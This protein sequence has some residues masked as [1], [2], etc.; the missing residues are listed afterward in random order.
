MIG[1][2]P[3]PY[4]D[5][6]LY[7]ICARFSNRVAYSSSKAVLL[8]VL[9]S[10]TAS[11]VIDLPNH[12]SHIITALPAGTSL[13]V[14]RLINQHSILPFFSSFVPPE[15]VRQLRK[16][17]R[18][19]GGPA[20]HM[21]SGVMA[22]RIPTPE[23]LRYCP[24]CKNEDEKKFGESYWHRVH[25]LPGVDV[26]SIHEIFLENSYVSRKSGRKHLQFTPVEG[27]T[28][29]QPARYLN[30]SDHD[31]QILLQIARDATWLLEHP[32]QGIDLHSLYN[33][34]LGLLIER[35]L[36]TYTGSI[37]VYKLLT[38]F[39]RYYSP[40]LLRLLHYEFTG[41]DQMKTNWL[42]RLVRPPKYAQHPLYH[43]LLMQLL[44]YTAEEFFKLPNE[45]ST[46][47]KGPWPC[48]NPTA[49]HFRKSVI[50]DFRLGKRLRSNRPVGIFSCECGFAYARSG[51]DSSQD[52]RFRIGKMISFG[53]VWEAKLNEL[54]KES[55]L[56]LSEIGRRLGVDPLT[57]RRHAARLNLSSSRG[58]KGSKPLELETKL[59]SGNIS[60][61]KQKRL[62]SCRSKWLSAMRQNPKI[63]LKTL[64]H[65]LA[66]HY[67]WLLQNDR[68][69]LE[70]HK[71]RDQRRK[72]STTSVDWKKRDAEYA[73]RVRDAATQLKEATA[74]PIRVTKTAIGRAIGAITLLQQKLRMMPLTTQVLAD[75]VETR[76]ECALRRVV[77]AATLYWQECALPREWQL[78]MRANVYSLRETSAV[79]CALEDAMEMLKSKLSQNHRIQAAS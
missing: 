4:P 54:W 36:A 42:L 32:R 74:R 22:S 77:W 10:I 13:T 12:L 11:A 45:L 34:Y 76:E 57:V 53:S 18:T 41:R 55:S 52:D 63:T 62:R 26:C 44:S 38:E 3:T 14:D 30:S 67:R 61:V 8:E 47:G 70:G 33:R 75:V 23:R 71:P 39:G 50:V 19:S 1:Y 79:K 37:R 59:K 78:V 58:G 2:F 43:L 7:S 9:G 29:T 69:W 35:G 24:V 20:A 17:M 16:D 6:L 60:A 31:H 49:D 56:S 28:Q 25:Q 21:R 27:A 46:F 72:L 15:R 5:E 68:K 73:V 48:L 65:K 40:S 51:P 64:R 66:R